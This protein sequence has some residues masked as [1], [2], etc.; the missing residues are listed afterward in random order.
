MRVMSVIELA[1]NT[2]QVNSVFNDREV[3]ILVEQGLKTLLSQG[4]MPIKKLSDNL[5]RAIPPSELSSEQ[6]TP[7]EDPSTR[8]R[9][10]A[11][12]GP[13]LGP[14][15]SERGNQ[16]DPDG[17]VRLVLGSQM[18]PRRQDAVQFDPA[19]REDDAPE[20]PQAA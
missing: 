9:N 19:R 6:T 16:P 14:V 15:E 5:Y 17:R 20:D 13:R 8:Y 1:G 7:N 12:S 10:S 3:A 18:A 4:L 2:Y 11:E